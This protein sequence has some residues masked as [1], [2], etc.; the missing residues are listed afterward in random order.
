MCLTKLTK[1]EERV[2]LAKLPNTFPCW[3]VIQDNGYCEY[4]YDKQEPKFT[5]RTHIAKEGISTSRTYLTYPPSFHAYLRKPPNRPMNILGRKFQVVKCYA[6]K[7]DIVRIG[8]DRASNY[9]ILAVAV[10]K[11]TRK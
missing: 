1:N 7:A 10:S 4:D 8:V 2:A 3:K 11:I 6:S 5:R 9:G